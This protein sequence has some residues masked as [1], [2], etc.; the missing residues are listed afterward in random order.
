MGGFKKT[1]AA[2]VKKIRCKCSCVGGIQVEI[3]GSDTPPTTPPMEIE[4]TISVT[5]NNT[6]QPSPM[7]HR[8]PAPLPRPHP[9]HTYTEV[10]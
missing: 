8:S 5:P 3:K 4:N 9:T 2:I 6:P 1:I 7:M 10:F